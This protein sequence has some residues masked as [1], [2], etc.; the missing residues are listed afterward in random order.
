MITLRRPPALSAKQ[1]PVASQASMTATSGPNKWR[2]RMFMDF[3]RA[4]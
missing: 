1:L 3:F 4:K 2:A